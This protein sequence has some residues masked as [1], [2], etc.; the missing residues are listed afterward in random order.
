MQNIQNTLSV[1]V[2]KFETVLVFFARI[3]VME[4]RGKNSHLAMAITWETSRIWWEI[5]LAAKTW[6]RASRGSFLFSEDHLW[7]WKQTTKC[8]KQRTETISWIQI[9]RSLLLLSRSHE[10][11]VS[12]RLQNRPILSLSDND[13]PVLKSIYL[14][15]SSPCPCRSAFHVLILGPERALN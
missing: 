1:P 6:Q 4:I 7:R 12:C 15:K 2:L 11:A 10:V 5:W 13:H 9:Q 8:K 3:T 14:H